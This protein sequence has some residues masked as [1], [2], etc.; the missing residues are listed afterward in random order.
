MLKP[1]VKTD[2]PSIKK[3]Q[4]LLEKVQKNDKD[5]VFFINMLKST[6][7]DLQ[8]KNKGREASL[9]YLNKK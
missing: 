6:I 4:D 3:Y 5:N 9:K 7:S 2:L 8:T 1:A